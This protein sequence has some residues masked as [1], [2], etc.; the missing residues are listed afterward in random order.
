MKFVLG[1]IIALLVVIMI[2]PQLNLRF[3]IL[4]AILDHRVWI[5]VCNGLFATYW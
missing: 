3:N 1:G 5:S 4:G 2:V